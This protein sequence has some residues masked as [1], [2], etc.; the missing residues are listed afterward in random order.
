[1]RTADIIFAAGVVLAIA[2]SL[3]YAP[4]IT[5]ERVAMQWGW[6][7]KP[8]WTAPKQFALWG[9]VAFMLALRLFIWFAETYLP[10]HVRG[11]EIGIAGV[12]I[13]A[14]AVHVFVLRKARRAG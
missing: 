11:V 6:D 12:G 13:I 9:M 8:T 10:Q 14:A 1:M 5:S 7:G 2:A 3:Y 4:R